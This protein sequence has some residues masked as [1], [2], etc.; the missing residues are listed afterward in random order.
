M[1]RVDMAK[2]KLD[3]KYVRSILHL[4]ALMIIVYVNV[5]IA[6]FELDHEI[7]YTKKKSGCQ[8]Q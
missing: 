3:V 6:E 5:V 1:A 2:I 8:N 7:G 4:K